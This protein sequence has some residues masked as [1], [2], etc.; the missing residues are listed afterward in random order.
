[1]IKNNLRKKWYENEVKNIYIKGTSGKKI[2][3]K[4]VKIIPAP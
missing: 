2:Y 4:R 1:L 3:K